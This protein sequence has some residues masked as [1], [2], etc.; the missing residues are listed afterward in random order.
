[1]QVLLFPRKGDFLELFLLHFSMQD[2]IWTY[3]KKNSL[4]SH[5]SKQVAI[6]RLWKYPDTNNI[7]NPYGIN[8]LLLATFYFLE[9]N[10]EDMI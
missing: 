8:I 1:M 3:S 2:N 10:L 4:D 6:Q 7:Y 5:L 9:G